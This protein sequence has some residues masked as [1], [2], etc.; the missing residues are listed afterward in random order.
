MYHNFLIHSSADGHLGCFHV[1][2]IINSAVMNPGVHISL[3]VLVSSVC[4]PAAWKETLKNRNYFKCNIG[5]YH[6]CPENP[7]LSLTDFAVFPLDWGFLFLIFTFLKV[8]PAH[9][10]NQMIPQGFEQKNS[11][12]VLHTFLLVCAT[13]QRNCF[14][15]LRWFFGC[16]LPYLQVIWFDCYF[17][18]F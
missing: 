5:E 9:F 13:S 16:L 2:A 10:K 11:S 4:M 15:L 1:L 8:M 3:S 7:P 14:H 18:I 6:E 17:L 12:S